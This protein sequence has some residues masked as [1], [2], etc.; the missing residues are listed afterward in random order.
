MVRVKISN[1]EIISKICQIN[2][3]FLKQPKPK[4]KK[5][6]KPLENATNSSWTAG[7]NKRVGSGRLHDHSAES[8]QRTLRGFSR[9]LAGLGRP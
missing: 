8:V 7:K 9:S 1:A 3:V 5:F 6:S 2:F 4:S